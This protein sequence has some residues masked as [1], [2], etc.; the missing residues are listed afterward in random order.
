MKTMRFPHSGA[1]LALLVLLGGCG[2]GD[3]DG[4]GGDGAPRTA[5]AGIPA[6]S[7]VAALSVPAHAGLVTR[8]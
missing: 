6:A 2:S 1:A 8:R 4:S 3:E 5:V 7:L